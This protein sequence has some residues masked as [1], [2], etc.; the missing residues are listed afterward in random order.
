MK[1]NFAWN[2]AMSVNHFFKADT[3]EIALREQLDLVEN[4]F[5]VE[6]TVSH[7]GVSKWVEMIFNAEGKFKGKPSYCI[8]INLTLRMFSTQLFELYLPM[9][10]TDPV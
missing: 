2:V 8:E 3:L 4:L 1:Q 5:I 7:R 6:S 9:S 10:L